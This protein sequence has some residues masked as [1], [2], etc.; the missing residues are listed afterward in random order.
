DLTNNGAVR[1]SV[2]RRIRTHFSLTPL[3]NLARIGRIRA[4]HPFVLVG[5]RTN[6]PAVRADGLWTAARRHAG[7]DRTL[8]RPQEGT[9]QETDPAQ[10]RG[11]EAPRRREKTRHRQKALRRQAVAAASESFRTR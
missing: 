4:N 1:A 5:G 11:G 7:G 10:S 3:P 9:A 6:V 2:V 8:R